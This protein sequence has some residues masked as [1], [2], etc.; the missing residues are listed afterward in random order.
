MKWGKAFLHFAPFHNL[1]IFLIS[2]F[3][4]FPLLI[5]YP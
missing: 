1:I 3:L 4:P 2:K 5:N